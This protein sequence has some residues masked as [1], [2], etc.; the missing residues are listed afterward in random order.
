MRIK[1]EIARQIARD[2]VVSV[3][4]YLLPV[5][6]MFLY[7]YF[8]GQRPWAE[9]RH[10]APTAVSHPAVTSKNNLP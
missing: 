2:A 5:A 6:L 9:A 1:K 7:F 4:I 3:F 10:A 8:S